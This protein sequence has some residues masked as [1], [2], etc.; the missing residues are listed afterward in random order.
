MTCTAKRDLFIKRFLSRDG[1]HMIV[2]HPTHEVAAKAE[3]LLHDTGILAE[4]VTEPTHDEIL[5]LLGA[6]RNCIG[7]QVSGTVKFPF[8]LMRWPWG[9]FQQ[10]L[11][12][13]ALMS[14]S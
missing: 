3:S 13:H 4:M 11:K 2:C 5:R 1:V 9:P 6:A 10:S 8:S 12:L 14:G 7:L